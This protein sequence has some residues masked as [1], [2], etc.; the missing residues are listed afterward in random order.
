MDRGVVCYM[1]STHYDVAGRQ[2]QL[3]KFKNDDEAVVLLSSIA[4]LGEGHNVTE[5]NHV[6][7]L[8]TFLEN[9]KYYQA[10][11]R[12]HRYPQNKPVYVHYLFNSSLDQKIYE[13]SQGNVDLSL[14]NWEKLLRE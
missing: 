5:A 3:E 9:N 2:R 6:I 7:F 12:C 1:F 14:L 10:I 11:G 13:H 8:S 4:M